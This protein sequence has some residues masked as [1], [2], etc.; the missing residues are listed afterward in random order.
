M[1]PAC[2]GETA[3]VVKRSFL[4]DHIEATVFE[5][6]PVSV[7]KLCSKLMDRKGSIWEARS[8]EITTKDTHELVMLMWVHHIVSIHCSDI[9]SKRG[10]NK[11]T[12]KDIV[13]LFSLVRWYLASRLCWGWAELTLDCSLMQDNLVLDNDNSF[14]VS[15]MG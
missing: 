2:R 6:G 4:I 3:K 15:T 13:C 9:A 5:N 14:F 11:Y 12:R 7:G 1:C 10:D 8:F